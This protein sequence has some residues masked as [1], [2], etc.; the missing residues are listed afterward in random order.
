MGKCP[1]DEQGFGRDAGDC[2]RVL[3][4]E[5]DALTRWSVSVYLEQWFEVITTD[6]ANEACRLLQERPV[7]ALV[8]SDDLPGSAVEQLG[9]LARSFNRKAAIVRTVTEGYD[10]GGSCERCLRLEKP[11]DLASLAR[12]LGIK[13]AKARSD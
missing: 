4:V 12:L 2:G 11:F 7:V 6:S 9:T 1:D 13:G 3:I 10:R 8:V 5:Q